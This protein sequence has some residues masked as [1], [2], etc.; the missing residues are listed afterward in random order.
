MICGILITKVLPC[1]LHPKRNPN[2]RRK[3]SKF[4]GIRLLQW[5][6]RKTSFVQ[7]H[8]PFHFSYRYIRQLTS[9]DVCLEILCQLANLCVIFLSFEIGAL[10][11]QFL[12][13]L[14]NK[15]WFWW[16][17]TGRR[18]VSCTTTFS[19]PICC[20]L[21]QEYK[22]FEDKSDNSRFL[23]ISLSFWNSSSIKL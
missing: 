6:N 22:S 17:G 13:G 5:G 10:P 18:R 14:V 9:Y 15:M 8:T 11:A 4:F 21:V 20:L 1:F 12:G 7:V 19:L 3:W 23:H 2:W 16:I